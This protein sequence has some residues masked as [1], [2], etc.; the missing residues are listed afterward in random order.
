MRVS[1]L[2]YHSYLHVGSSSERSSVMKSCFCHSEE[3]CEKKLD[4][5]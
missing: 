2:N 3:Y 4:K 5:K 1:F